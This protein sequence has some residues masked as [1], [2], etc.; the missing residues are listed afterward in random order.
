MPS[1]GTGA[2]ASS[3]RQVLF[4]HGGG[5]GTHDEWDD[6]LVGSL[7]RELG[8]G[9]E[10][11][12]PRMPDEGDPSYPRW[13]TAIQR[14]LAQLEPGAIVVAHS[15]GA[16][17]LIGML[18]E[19]TPPQS[20]GAVV[21][22]AAPFVG[23]GGWPSDDL[24]FPTDLDARLPRGVPIFVFHGLLDETAPHSHADLYARAIPRA[25]VRKLP[26]R[27][28]QLNNN[29]HEVADAIASLSTHDTTIT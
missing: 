2:S 16:A 14:E 24:A 28:H 1:T 15:A 25:I 4:I 10:I 17:I 12:Y 20:L 29:L 13:S 9:F 27:D 3:T 23:Q 6:E 8:N 18:A 11:H 22:I 19:R 21:L 26:D 5:A 7:G